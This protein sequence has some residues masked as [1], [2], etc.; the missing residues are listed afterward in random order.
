MLFKTPSQYTREERSPEFR[1]MTN[2]FLRVR[3]GNFDAT[4]ITYN[5]MQSRSRTLIARI[6]DELVTQTQ[7]GGDA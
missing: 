3:Y 5:E 1:D 2:E 4:E 6:S 7:E